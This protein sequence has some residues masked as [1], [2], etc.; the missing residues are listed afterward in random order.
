MHQEKG[1]RTFQCPC[2][3]ES[4]WYVASVVRTSIFSDRN[5]KENEKERSGGERRG[6]PSREFN[7]LKCGVVL[8][9]RF[10]LTLAGVEIVDKAAQLRQVK[11]S[12]DAPAY[13]SETEFKLV[14]ICRAKGI[15]QPFTEVVNVQTRFSDYPPR[16]YDKFF[17]T[18]LH[19]ATRAT[20]G[21]VFM[22]EFVR[23]FPGRVEFWKSQGIGMVVSNRR[24]SR[25]VPMR[26]MNLSYGRI[27]KLKVYGTEINR[28]AEHFDS[29]RRTK[30]GYVP[31]SG[32]IFLE[33]L[34]HSLGDQRRQM[35][36][37]PLKPKK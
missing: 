9:L 18:F 8:Q 28:Q 6:V 23:E 20:I 2:C 22:R 19:T 31:E 14:Q 26:S 29:I 35:Q 4:L 37:V 34:M 10:D 33:E 17:I 11:S 12:K 32:R 24:I 30:F 13:F 25:F 3:R 27:S 21:D 1:E 36:D 15:L 16:H 7:C 5:P